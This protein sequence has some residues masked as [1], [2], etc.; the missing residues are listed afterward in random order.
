MQSGFW[1]GRR[2]LITGHTG[3]KGAWLCLLLHRLGAQV[4]GYAL[5][6]PTTPSLYER[7]GIDALVHSTLGDVRDLALLTRVVT[8][9]APEVLIH[10]AAQSVVLTSYEDPVDTYATNVM[11]TVNL[12]EAVRRSGCPMTVVN[13]TTDK[14]YRNEGWVWSY[15]E[16]DALGGR[17]PYS[18]SKA[19]AELVAQAFRQSFFPVDAFD[20]HR[21]AIASARAGN[22]IGGGDWTAHQ[23]VPAVVEA[24]AAGRPVELR[25][26][27]AIRPWQHVLDCLRGYLTLA[28][29]LATDP[30]KHSGEWN[31]GPATDDV[32]TVAQVTEALAPHW[33]LSPP[34]TTAAASH[35]HEELELRLDSSKAQR[36]MRWRCL[37]PTAQALEWVARWYRRTQAGEGARA[38]CDDQIDGFLALEP[39][40]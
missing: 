39:R 25:N 12:L 19:C 10:M 21:V 36:L 30:A 26:P 18:N 7:A 1:H 24:C 13:V 5:A 38:V 11:G 29:H 15:R 9:T 33:N 22:V 23:L 4:S 37:L 31:F 20:D 16:N 28:Q 32:F 34:W 6:P 17:D 2:V 40:A 27:S 35:P 8:E 3:F 14:A